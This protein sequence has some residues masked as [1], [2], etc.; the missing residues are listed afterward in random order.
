MNPVSQHQNVFISFVE[1]ATKKNNFEKSPAM[2]KRSKIPDKFSCDKCRFSSRDMGQFNKHAL[3]HV[4]M[5]FSC[6]YCNHVSYTRGESQRHLVKH[7]GTFPFKCQFCPYG[8]VR[9]DYIVKHTQRVHKVF[10]DKTSYR[11]EER[12][13]NLEQQPHSTKTH[14]CTSPMNKNTGLSPVGL[15]SKAPVNSAAI[16]KRSNASGLSKVQVELLS[17]LHEPIQHDKPLTIAYPPEMNIP[18]GCFVELVE[19]KTVNG[20]KELE[21]KLVSQHAAETESPVKNLQVQTGVGVQNSH[22]DKPTFR[23]SVIPQENKAICLEPHTVNQLVEKR[24]LSLVKTMLDVS[25]NRDP[26]F[27]KHSKETGVAVKEEPGSSQHQC[28]TVQSL[29]G[30]QVTSSQVKE[31]RSNKISPCDLVRNPVHAPTN[32][33]KQIILEDSV[34]VFIPQGAVLKISESNKPSLTLKISTPASE[35]TGSW[36]PRPVLFS[37]LNEQN[38]SD[39]DH[40]CQ[41]KVPKLSLKRRKS[42]AEN[43]GLDEDWEPQS[44]QTHEENG[45]AWKLAKHKKRK[46]HKK[47][48]KVKSLSQV[49]RKTQRDTGRLWLI[50]LKEDQL[51]KCPGPDQPVVVLN[52]PKPQALRVS[53]NIHTMLRG[54]ESFPNSALHTGEQSVLWKSRKT[55]QSP[56]QT[57]HTLKMKLKKVHQNKYQVVGFVFRD[58]PTETQVLVR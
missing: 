30:E 42:G 41:N 24:D 52:H 12:R 34:P 32:Q 58:S 5:T 21:L 8:A 29:K 25:H 56:D 37:S 47:A 55:R 16:G 40:S 28:I 19:V 33:K 35:T 9:N 36:M 57:Q 18:P 46:K 10:D 39:T 15:V 2:P 49:M 13:L 20:T 27:K 38:I 11:L 22:T 54:N 6:S 17:P 1:N 50:P 43:K 51:V 23:C 4:E 14:V 7:T 26:E 3:Q 44:P 48:S 31:R 53:T 45:A